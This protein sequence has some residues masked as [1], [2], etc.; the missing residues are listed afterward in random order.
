MSLDL[1]NNL[2]SHP[3][4]ELMKNE[5]TRKLD[6]SEITLSNPTV[7]SLPFKH[8]TD[9][10]GSHVDLSPLLVGPRLGETRW[11]QF[12]NTN[13]DSAFKASKTMGRDLALL[14]EWQSSGLKVSEDG[15]IIEDKSKKYEW[16]GVDIKGGGQTSIGETDHQPTWRNL[17]MVGLSQNR[18]QRLGVFNKR[19]NL[20]LG[21]SGQGD[22]RG[23]CNLVDV[24]QEFNDSLRF[25]MMGARVSMPLFVGKIGQNDEAWGGRIKQGAELGI[26]A[27]AY[28]SPFTWADLVSVPIDRPD[29]TFS[30]LH[31][32]MTNLRDEGLLISTEFDRV[33]NVPDNIT[34]GQEVSRSYLLTGAKIMGD[35][36]S[37]IHSVRAIGNRNIQNT[38]TVFEHRDV[39]D[40]SPRLSIYIGEKAA[41]KLD[42]LFK[43]VS[44]FDDI[45]TELRNFQTITRTL[46]PELDKN[47]ELTVQIWQEYLQSYFDN[48]QGLSI[49]QFKKQ[50][51]KYVAGQY[52]NAAIERINSKVDYDNVMSNV[53]SL[54]QVVKN[55]EIKN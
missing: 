42:F 29:E 54:I 23:G 25:F 12:A 47:K 5:A 46:I 33:M 24:T 7:N 44:K 43:D 19:D 8:V 9:E 49:K 4:S 20:D 41:E 38:S 40:N 27:R 2:T 52:F 16:E 34:K 55:I 10:T 15:T 1:P 31:H 22:L 48:G 35:D 6:I 21:E 53:R 18:R 32:A 37:L 14:L 3:H 17:S 50:M 28:R 39:A 45:I 13:V 51:N 26:I 36:L 30:V 11:K